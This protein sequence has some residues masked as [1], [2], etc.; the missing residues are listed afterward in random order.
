M[1]EYLAR[2]CEGGHKHAHLK[3]GDRTKKA[4][5]YTQ[6]F[7]QAIV[8]GYKVHKAKANKKSIKKKNG[9]L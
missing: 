5:I 3:G 6:E 7:C 2:Q 1:G 4:A 8:D 9:K